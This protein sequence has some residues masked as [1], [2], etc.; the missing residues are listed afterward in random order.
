M[1]SRKAVRRRKQPESTNLGSRNLLIK[2]C[3]KNVNQVNSGSTGES[4]Y[5]ILLAPYNVSELSHRKIMSRQTSKKEKRNWS[6]DCGPKKKLFQMAS[7]TN[8]ISSRRKHSDLRALSSVPA[9][10][11]LTE[12]IQ[13][14]WETGVLKMILVKYGHSNVLL[15][16]FFITL[17][18]HCKTIREQGIWIYGLCYRR[19]TA[20]Q[21]VGTLFILACI[22]K[23]RALGL[24]L[25]AAL[26]PS[27]DSGVATGFVLS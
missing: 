7:L 11:L 1:H 8:I 22:V 19:F 24:R 6:F 13:A 5:I 15:F 2:I 16:C 3:N 27:K 21:Q 12:T 18:G 23:A 4:N 20:K 14:A 26:L 10:G 9:W 25:F 17:H